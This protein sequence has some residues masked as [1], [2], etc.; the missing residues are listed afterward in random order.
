MEKEEKIPET[1]FHFQKQHFH[2]GR[3][4]F[5]EAQAGLQVATAWE[6]ACSSPVLLEGAPWTGLNLAS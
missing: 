5:T 4:T 3:P 1:R 2:S 6:S